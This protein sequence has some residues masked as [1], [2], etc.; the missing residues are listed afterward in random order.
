MRGS[1]FLLRKIDHQ[2]LFR[3]SHFPAVIS[4]TAS[5]ARYYREFGVN[6][7]DSLVPTNRFFYGV[8][9]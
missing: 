7:P 3:R 5:A 4:A 2:S 8:K 9:R 1:E 6:V